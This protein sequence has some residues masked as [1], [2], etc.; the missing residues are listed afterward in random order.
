MHQHECTITRWHKHEIEQAIQ[1]L[2]KRGYELVAL[3]EIVQD[4]KEFKSDSFRRQIFVGN[5]ISSKWKA[6]LRRVVE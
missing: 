1:D 4:G 2:Q 3:K 6:K 5:V